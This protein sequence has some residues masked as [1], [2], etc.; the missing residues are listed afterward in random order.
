[1]QNRLLLAGLG[2]LLILAAA[3]VF[4]LA[5]IDPPLP[6]ATAQ[7]DDHD[8]DLELPPEPVGRTLFGGN[9]GELRVSPAVPAGATPGP[10]FG[11]TPVAMPS[12]DVF[13]PARFQVTPAA[14]PSATAGTPP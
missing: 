4:A 6:I 12:F 13:A 1:M 3:L 11:A 10:R 5:R 2:I 9:S 14:A 7:V 8:H